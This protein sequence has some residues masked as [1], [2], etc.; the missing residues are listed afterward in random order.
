MNKTQVHTD[1]ETLRDEVLKLVTKKNT[2]Q[3]EDLF[4]TVLDT[5][6]PKSGGGQTKF[7]MITLEDKNYYYCRYTQMY[8]EESLMVMSGG[9]SKGY[10]KKA[11]S[12]WNKDGRDALVLKDQATEQLLNDET[13]NQGKETYNQ[14]LQMLELRNK[15]ERYES[16]KDEL[17]G[18]EAYDCLDNTTSK[19]N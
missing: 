4:Q 8:H 12:I 10:S 19:V 7:P 9:K 3:V 17:L 11:I 14:H 18:D 2:Q 15:P 13:K 6:K 1:I 16:L 5:Y